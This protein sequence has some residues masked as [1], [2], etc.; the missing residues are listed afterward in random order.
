MLF[1][2]VGPLP[3]HLNCINEV[4]IEVELGNLGQIGVKVAMVD[5]T[6][7]KENGPP[8]LRTAHSVVLIDQYV[9]TEDYVLSI[10]N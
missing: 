5:K 10:S 6:V 4:I 8:P 3:V 7:R 2:L 9:I 1:G